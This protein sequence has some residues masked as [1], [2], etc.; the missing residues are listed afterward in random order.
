V[1]S[2]EFWCAR[3]RHGYLALV[4]VGLGIIPW[5]YHGAG[6]RAD[7][8]SAVVGRHAVRWGPGGLSG[9]YGAG[10]VGVLGWGLMGGVG[11][12]CLLVGLL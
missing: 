12:L 3:E 9:V 4:H 8:G 5:G 2:T 1:A 10:T 11:L 6:D 7:G